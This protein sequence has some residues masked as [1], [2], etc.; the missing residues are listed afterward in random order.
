MPS[1]STNSQYHNFLQTCHMNKLTAP[2]DLWHSL[3]SGILNGRYFASCRVEY[4]LSS[5]YVIFWHGYFLSRYDHG[6]VPYHSGDQSDI[7]GWITRQPCPVLLVWHWWRL[8]D[9]LVRSEKHDFCFHISTSTSST[10]SILRQS[11]ADVLVQSSV[12]SGSLKSFTFKDVAKHNTREDLYFVVH[13]RVYNASK[14]IDS[15]P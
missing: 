9:D 5:W 7:C 12:M 11:S 2:N 13:D 8:S 4:T 6:Q 1:I 15:H 10:C 3:L 14:F